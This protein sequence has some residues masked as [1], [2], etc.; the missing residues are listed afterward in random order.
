M[1]EER[2]PDDALNRF[3]NALVQSGAAPPEGDLDAVQAE[4]VRRLHAM[5]RAPLPKEVQ[6][7]VDGAVLEDRTAPR[8]GLQDDAHLPLR[9][10]RSRVLARGLDATAPSGQVPKDRLPRSSQQLETS[11]LRWALAQMATA[12]LLVLTLLVSYVAF[13][14]LPFGRQVERG[15]EMPPPAAPSAPPVAW[16][17]ESI[18]LH[19]TIDA[20]PD[21]AYWI[22]I[23][24]T[25]LEPGVEFTRGKGE[26]RG[27]GPL[28]LRVE[29]GALTLT[30]NGPMTVT[31][32][33]A[34]SPSEIPTGADVTLQPG[35]QGFTP[36]GVSTHWRNDG[37]TPVSVL[38][39]GIMT[40]G[41]DWQASLTGRTYEELLGEYG[42]VPFH[43]PVVMT[44]SR[45]TLS[46]GETL[47]VDATPGLEMLTVETGN[48]VAIDAAGSGKTITP[49]AFD[50]GTASQGNFRP[51]RVFRG[52]DG[53]PVTLLLMTIT[54][55]DGA[56]PPPGP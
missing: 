3:W 13:G 46:G 17:E 47:A 8:G 40:S 14:P 45:V 4:T 37:T 27:D 10:H 54:P 12:L 28:L 50:K 36:A 56:T 44:V 49:F 16:D 30:A 6:A 26:V 53:T 35:D 33:D 51:G 31:R 24:R 43:A 38:Q 32:A 25:V 1:V 42:S 22:G 29:S 2:A 34:T 19:D 52:A 18:L 20:I 41:L 11:R 5:T 9:L 7:R 15:L 55:A 48:L 21:V 23:G 39:A